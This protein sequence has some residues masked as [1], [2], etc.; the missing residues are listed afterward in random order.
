M[1]E[2]L[3]IPEVMFYPSRMRKRDFFDQI[4]TTLVVESSQMADT[5]VSEAVSGV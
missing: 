4:L 5:S 3:D 1:E 2:I